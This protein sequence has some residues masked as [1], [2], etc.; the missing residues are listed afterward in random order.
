MDLVALLYCGRYFAGMALVLTEG[1]VSE[2]QNKVV[3]SD[4]VYTI[5]KHFYVDEN[6]SRMTMSTSKG[7][8]VFC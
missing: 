1:R 3:V 7:H 8:Q 6:G 2:N 5:V 4:D